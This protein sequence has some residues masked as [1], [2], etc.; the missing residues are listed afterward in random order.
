MGVTVLG[1][2]SVDG[3][4]VGS[5]R[6]RLVLSALV[7]ENGRDVSTDTFVELVWGDSAPATAAKSLQNVIVELRRL[8][9]PDAI[10]TS[11]AG[12]RLSVAPADLDVCVFDSSSG[13]EALAL[14]GGAPFDEL[15]HWPAAAAERAR[16]VERHDRLVESELRSAIGVGGHQTA[17]A[18]L[19]RLVALDPLHE[20]WWEL[21]VIALYRSGRQRDALAALARNRE[22][23]RTEL[24]V[25]VS[26][27]MDGLERAVLDQAAWLGTGPLTAPVPGAL[28]ALRRD[29]W[30]FAGR[31]NE[32]AVLE[33]AWHAARKGH[34]GL[35]VLMGEPGIGKSRL[36]AELA[37]T[38]AL[39][40]GVV[41]YGRCD[42]GPGVPFAVAAELIRGWL[43]DHHA[44]RELPTALRWIVPELG[45]LPEHNDL[46]NPTVIHEAVVRF[47]LD[48]A[49]H[50]PVMVI[51]DD[52][53]WAQP[54]TAALLQ[55][56]ARRVIGRGVHM[57]WT[58]R[59]DDAV[60]QLVGGLQPTTI[61]L[62]PLTEA[63]IAEMLRGELDRSAARSVWEATGGHPFFAAAA[64]AHLLQHGTLGL[65]TSAGWVVREQVEH[66]GI[67]AAR[68]LT[69]AGVIGQEFS[70]EIASEAEDLAAADA[71]DLLERAVDLGL[72]RETGV[73]RWRFAHDLV[74]AHLVDGLTVS[75]RALLHARVAQVIE[76]NA[77]RDVG[78]LAHHFSAA[79][80]GHTG[81]ARR[82]LIEAGDAAAAVRGFADATSL[83]EQAMEIGGRDAHTLV[84]QASAHAG[85]GDTGACR[86]RALEASRAAYVAGDVDSLVE[87]ALV[88]ARWTGVSG[89]FVVDRERIVMLTRALDAI[90]PASTADRALLL[91]NVADALSWD[92]DGDLREQM[93]IDAIA[94]LDSDPNAS[95][96]EQARVWYT[97]STARRGEHTVERH[98]TTDRLT[99]LAERSDDPYV[100]YAAG[101]AGVIAAIE[102]GD[103]TMAARWMLE[104][105]R[106][107]SDPRR[108]NMRFMLFVLEASLAAV[109]GELVA[110]EDL[111]QQ[112][113][114]AGTEAGHTDAAL[115]VQL[116]LTTIR[117]YQDRPADVQ[118]ANDA[119][120][121][122]PTMEVGRALAAFIAA[123]FGDIT[124][125]QLALDDL[126]GRGLDSIG[127]D[128]LY[129]AALTAWA[130][131]AHAVAHR[132]AAE[133]LRPALEPFAGHLQHTVP[134]INPPVDHALGSLATTLE[135]WSDAD[136]W[137]TSA[138]ELEQ[139]CGAA[140]L[141]GLT[142]VAWAD[143]LLARAPTQPADP[144][145]VGM[146]D[147]VERFGRAHGVVMLVRR[148]G[149]VRAIRCLP[150]P[151]IKFNPAAD[152]L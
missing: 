81:E 122:P 51:V 91:A 76:R 48:L 132:R 36:A 9:G 120:A 24:G 5:R 10:A 149:E 74:R 29:R 60:H 56:M 13:H 109:A 71:L 104:I 22:V 53:H 12:Y 112:A 113:L 43:D 79:G 49:E 1:P 141:V 4:Q 103:R 127:H 96:Q 20:P 110:A 57:I 93:C 77:P 88:A 111:L 41:V 143:S 26:P 42:E 30:A 89:S 37:S 139:R 129:I 90:G 34:G 136:R 68:L 83:Y 75:R 16:L 84:K 72:L 73:N 125:A 32:R 33:R 44:A 78:A 62:L 14:W 25:D 140:V 100:L 82:Y 124:A 98:A 107:T 40:G 131:T 66:L 21:L 142:K 118:K 97:V 15:S 102:R 61:E 114:A 59:T 63:Q 108:A 138:L 130:A 8:L 38:A 65:T 6:A 2:V 3:R 86:E 27:I 117:R 46:E 58:A 95:P 106:A 101:V 23:M 80:P 121:V 126:L 35:A 133:A 7:V 67:D 147:D 151:G 18:D 92:A 146:L 119:V 148:V 115:L 11:A 137:F 85:L 152:A 47:L 145:A 144:R 45:P 54:A 52:V 94:A 87:A 50:D 150:R 64:A 28:A 116:S 55:H 105:D 31:S 69:T 134:A 128:V 19:E 17:V 99:T 39:D 70:L 123:K 135:R